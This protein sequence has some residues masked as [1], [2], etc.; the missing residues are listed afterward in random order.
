MGTLKAGTALYWDPDS[1][2]AL[3][4]NAMQEEWNAAYPD[5]PLPDSGR[6]DRLVMFAAVAKGVLRYLHQHQ[7]SIGTTAVT[8]TTT[9]PHDHTLQFDVAEDTGP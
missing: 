3:I 1:M 5:K 2:T 7:D 9:D 8:A 4:E 6:Q